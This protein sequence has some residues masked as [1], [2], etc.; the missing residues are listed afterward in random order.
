DTLI[1]IDD[2]NSHNGKQE[3]TTLIGKKEEFTPHDRKQKLE[4]KYKIS[5]KNNKRYRNYDKYFVYSKYIK[6]ELSKNFGDI[7]KYLTVSDDKFFSMP[8]EKVD[9]EIKYIS[10]TEEKDEMK[11]VS[12]VEKK[13]KIEIVSLKLPHSEVIVKILVFLDENKLIMIS[14][15]P[16]Y[17]IYIFIREDNEFIH[18]STIKVETYNGKIFLSNGKLF[19]YEENLGNITKWD[20]NTSKFEAYFLFNNS[21]D[22]DNM[23][24]ND[25]EA[26]LFVYSKNR[27]DSWHKNPY[28][29]ISVY[30]TDHGNKLT[31]F[32]LIASD[33]GARLL[34]VHHKKNEE[35]KKYY[36]SICDPFI[37]SILKGS[38]ADANELFKDFEAS[39]NEIFENKCNIKNNKIVGTLKDF[40]RIFM[41]SVVEKIIDL[42][43]KTEFKNDKIEQAETKTD[44]IHIVP[45]SYIKSDMNVEEFVKECDC[46]DND[47]LVMVMALGV[48]I[49]TFNTKDSKIES[50]LL[51]PSSYISM[52]CHNLAFSQLQLQPSKDR[53]FF[54]ALI[55]MHIK[56]KFPLIFNGQKLIEDIIKEDE[57]TLLWKVLNRCIEQ[58]EK[59]KETLNIQI[60]K[61]F[62]RLITK[63]F[64]KY[65]LFFEDEL[66]KLISYI[67][68]DNW[69][70]STK[71]IITKIMKILKYE[72]QESEIDK[73]HKIHKNQES[74]ADKIHKIHKKQESDAD[75]IYKIYEKQQSEANKIQK[76][77]DKILKICEKHESEADKIQK[78]YEKQENFQK[79]LEKIMKKL[80]IQSL[81][82]H[83]D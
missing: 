42:I 68:S 80:E 2:H 34:I 3:F 74:E 37:P 36:Y 73:I 27:G 71:P 52:I 49:W 30:F 53:F 55:E 57:E 8:I 14:K 35:E 63:I 39:C 66:H 22:I 78:M 45:E 70:E 15:D 44:S 51:P 12:K 5:L 64:K 20:I 65:P 26:F 17:R 33:I 18:Q 10:K 7:R 62:S 16:L 48:L 4:H 46:L 83:D 76:M 31:T 19:R 41:P 69:K 1:S 56:S 77:S 29:C 54:K 59:D 60:F 25:N 81:E 21:F 43:V 32:Y 67:N 72:K 79:I 24:L 50:Y 6:S 82:K 58:I 11:V 61:I 75:K 23:K 9:L 13:I 47:D 38:F 40:N 28:Q